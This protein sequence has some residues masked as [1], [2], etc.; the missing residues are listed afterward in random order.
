MLAA[1]CAMLSTVRSRWNSAAVD[2]LG[3]EDLR[4]QPLNQASD[5]IRPGGGRT[6]EMMLALR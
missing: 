2:P 3:G 1:Q 6:A 5:R 4:W